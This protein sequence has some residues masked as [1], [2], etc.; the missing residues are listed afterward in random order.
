M[1]YVNAP[2]ITDDNLPDRIRRGD[3]AAGSGLV[4]YEALCVLQLLRAQN[5]SDLDKIVRTQPSILLVD[6]SEVRARINFLINLFSENLPSSSGK[7]VPAYSS[8]PARAGSSRHSQ[9]LDADLSGPL[10][11]HRTDRAMLHSAARLSDG[12]ARSNHSES[13]VRIVNLEGAMGVRPHTGHSHSSSFSYRT[14]SGSDPFLRSQAG[15]RIS[16]F[17]AALDGRE[18]NNDAKA[19]AKS[20]LDRLETL[21]GSGVE[22]EITAESGIGALSEVSLNVTAKSDRDVAHQMLCT[23]LLSYPAVLSIEHRYVFA[24]TL[25][26]SCS[27]PQA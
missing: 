3:S 27:V 12:S 17:Q 10:G 25:F 24:L 15:R 11:Q 14:G 13:G 22:T 1:L 23:L 6:S 19:I 26:F 9:S 18:K 20:V 5:F 21:K 2:Q 16:S 7:N 8:G 4:A